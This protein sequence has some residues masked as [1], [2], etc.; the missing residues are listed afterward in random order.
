MAIGYSQNFGLNTH[1]LS[2]ALRSFATRTRVPRQELMR[3]LGVGNNKAEA[4]VTWLGYLGLR[5]NK[6]GSLT[7]LGRLLVRSDPH[8]QRTLT[9]WLLHYQLASNGQAEVWYILSN[10]FLPENTTFTF[11]DALIFLAARGLPTDQHLRSDLGIFLSAFLSPEA[12]ASTGYIVAEGTKHRVL[13]RNRFRRVISP[14]VP[15]PL[16]AYVIYDQQER[17]TPNLTTITISE[18]LSQRANVGRVFSVGRA[19]LE[20]ALRMLGSAQH[21][22][23]V[24]LAM[25]AGLDQVVLEFRG[26]PLDILSMHYSTHDAK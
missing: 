1:L 14:D 5:V 8:L 10:E 11:K 23:L 26:S 20:E 22:N 17:N 18:L 19:E 25:S 3:I 16:L 15:L 6:T 21:G 24:R 4:T 2:A 9:L 7:S 13:S 12:L